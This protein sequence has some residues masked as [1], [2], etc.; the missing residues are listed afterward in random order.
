MIISH[1][2]K[3]IFIKTRKTAGTSI[4]AYLSQYC[5]RGDILSPFGR[6]VDIHVPRNYKGYFNPIPEIIVTRGKGLKKALKHFR[7]QRKFYNH[8]PAHQVRA[9]ISR[10]IWNNYFKFCVERNPWDKTLS[11]YFFMKQKINHISSLE[12]YLKA[13]LFCLNYP[14]YTGY[15]D[16]DTLL[17]DRIV[18][19]EKLMDELAEIFGMLGVPFNNSLNVKAKGSYRKDRRHYRDVLTAEQKK[20]IEHIFEKEITMHAYEY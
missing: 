1:K 13:G 6:P 17:V 10:R 11:H 3:F 4:E 14:S 5:H 7:R 2:Y 19:Y 20:I 15:Q 12:D 9:R 8:I 18:K 16:P